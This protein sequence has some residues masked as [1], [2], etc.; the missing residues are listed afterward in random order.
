MIK[1]ITTITL[2]LNTGSQSR[3]QENQENQGSRQ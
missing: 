2:I 1:K 3:N